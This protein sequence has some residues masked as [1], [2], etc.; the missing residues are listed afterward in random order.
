MLG[1]D[2]TINLYDFVV[3]K[4][5]FSNQMTLRNIDDCIW[6]FECEYDG[7]HGIIETYRFICTCPDQGQI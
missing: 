1:E 7:F 2:A 5:I 3:L 6:S 4:L